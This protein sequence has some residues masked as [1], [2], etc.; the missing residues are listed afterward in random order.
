[1]KDKFVPGRVYLAQRL[2]FSQTEASYEIYDHVSRP[3]RE[4]SLIND[5]MED[6]EKL[7][8]RR[9]IPDQS[10][11]DL[12]D[13][14]YQASVQIALVLWLCCELKSRIGILYVSEALF[15]RLNIGVRRTRSLILTIAEIYHYGVS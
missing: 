1:M 9:L 13:P 3:V 5:E 12:L 8:L 10:L 2:S 14:L 7:L 4:H 6:R 15:N 11:L